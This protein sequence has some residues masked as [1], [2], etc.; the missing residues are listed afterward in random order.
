VQVIR[1]GCSPGCHLGTAATPAR[2]KTEYQE[3]GELYYVNDGHRS[4]E[5]GPRVRSRVSRSMCQIFF[6]PLQ[7]NL[8]GP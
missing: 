1:F 2:H 5:P 7:I 4:V 3:F 6:C 8:L